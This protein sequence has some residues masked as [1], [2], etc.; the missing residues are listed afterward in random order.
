MA[1]PA[2]LPGHTTGIVA[3]RVS[4]QDGRAIGKLTDLNHLS[5]LNKSMSPAKYD[6]DIITLYTQTSTAVSDFQQMLMKSTPFE[7]P[8]GAPDYWMWEAATI[9][10]FPKI[11]AVPDSTRTNANAGIDNQIF[12]FIMDKEAF[13]KNQVITANTRFGQEFFLVA[14]PEP[15]G[16]AFLYKAILVSSNPTSE[17]VDKRWLAE[18]TEYELVRTLKGEWTQDAPGLAGMA[19]KIQLFES[20]GAGANREHTI[21][22][23]A[24]ERNISKDADIMM[25][26]KM[27]RNEQGYKVTATSWEPMIERLL[28]EDLLKEGMHSAIWGKGGVVRER[29]S[30][31]ELLKYSA[32]LYHRIRTNGNLRQYF[33]GGFSINFLRGIFGDLFYRRVSMKDRRVKLY[34]NEAG[35]DV[36]DQALKADAMGSGITLMDNGTGSGFIEGKG[37]HRTLNFAFDSV[38]TRETGM[39][40]LIH[41]QELEE[42]QSNSNIGQNKKA[43]PVF[44]VFDVSPNS[45]GSL[46]NNL[47]MV[48]RQGTPLLR[49]NYVDGQMSH[50]GPMASQGH[51]AANSFDGYK[52]DM[53]TRNDIFIEDLSRCV[54]IEELPLY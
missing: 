28:R 3:K 24:E 47:R 26:A 17:V 33:R 10:K 46:T 25:Y 40:S 23:W 35:F 14:D 22:G 32:G 18:G 50:L 7:I 1:F 37:Q 54:L 5:S 4:S 48:K 27:E 34:T 21:T 41:L 8:K 11:I 51:N 49:W 12:E 9:Y 20:L 42:F 31:Q 39:I 13:W 2:S 44:L 6:K 30:K 29:S 15:Y 43:T 36:F 45:D 52:I 19:D 16:T 38:I 53:S